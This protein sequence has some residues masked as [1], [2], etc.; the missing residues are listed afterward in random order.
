MSMQR[1]IPWLAVLLLA[2]LLIAGLLWRSDQAQAPVAAGPLLSFDRAAVD[3]IEIDD[4][5]KRLRLS[6]SDGS[7]VLPEAF[8]FPAG[9]FRVT[10]L[11]D[12]LAELKGGLPLARSSEAA[13]R[14]RV[15][16]DGYERRVRLLAGE[17]TMAE[18]YLGDAAGPRRAYGRAA[19]DEAIY[20]LPFTA[21]DADADLDGWTDKTVLHR[22]VSD[23]RA[24]RLGD[25]A[26]GREQGAWQLADLG[27]GRLTDQDAAAAL[28]AR[29]AGLNFA[30]VHGR[31][32]ELPV[33]EPLLSA[34]LTLA[35]GNEV[36]YRF[37][38]PGQQGDPLLWVSDRPH[39]LRIASYVF[40]PLKEVSR[41]QLVKAVAVEVPEQGEA[42]PPARTPESA[43]AD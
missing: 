29:I 31:A 41:A 40:A 34:V 36:E 37:I 17:R 8:D 27:E 26:L 30:G 20:A 16:A 11:L 10:A 24:L 18:L 32:E 43:A 39:V 4:G 19:G 14:F 1:W 5:D 6:R 3:G 9:E 7:W 22:Q 21:F 15:A 2:Q 38:D 25:I 42:V 33:G 23:I 35:D 12:N 28:V 13:E